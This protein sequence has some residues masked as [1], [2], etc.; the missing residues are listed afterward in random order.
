MFTGETMQ[1][2]LDIAWGILVGAILAGVAVWLAL[3]PRGKAIAL[4][5]PPPT[6]TPAPLWV[7]VEGAVAHPG[8]YALPQ[9]SRVRDAIQAAGGT[10]PQALPEALNLAARLQDGMRV[11]VPFRGTPTP[12]AQIPTTVP[13]STGERININT[14][15]AETL[16]T[17]PHIGP[18]LAQRIVA[19]RTQH[20]PF[21]SVDD[22]LAV[23]G[24]GPNVLDDIRDL[25]TVGP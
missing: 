9:G 6:P 25:I 10:T 2:W 8:V 23:K 18:T 24:I 20:G 21:Q 3:P 7:D 19:Y 4:Q 22:L 13:L 11:Y 1:R 15:S 14:A 5:P 17:L 16:E 12:V